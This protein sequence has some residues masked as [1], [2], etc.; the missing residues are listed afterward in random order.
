MSSSPPNTV[1]GVARCCSYEAIGG[2]L[3]VE[4][5]LQLRLDVRE[6]LFRE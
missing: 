1:F 5:A 4:S 3:K 6:T 2:S